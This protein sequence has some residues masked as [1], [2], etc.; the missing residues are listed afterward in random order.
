[1]ELRKADTAIRSG[2]PVRDYY[3]RLMRTA[4]KS[5]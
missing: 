2:T 5:L 4:K 3:P 1:V